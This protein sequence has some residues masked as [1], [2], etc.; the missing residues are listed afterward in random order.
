MGYPLVFFN[1]QRYI[2]GF[3][4]YL[5][6]ILNAVTAKIGGINYIIENE[7]NI[8]QEPAI[9]AIRHES[10]WETLILIHKFKEPIF[11]LKEELLNI[12]L[13]G[14][15]SRKAGTISI[16]RN[17]GVESLKNAISQVTKAVE[18]GH[19]VIIFPEGTRMAY[20]EYAPLKRG[21]ALFYKKTNCRVVPVIHNAG[22]LWPRR[23]FIK[24]QGTI[25]VKFLNPIV[26][27]LSDNEFMD[28]LNNVFSSEIKK[29][30]APQKALA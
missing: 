20:G 25:M 11:V 5:S 2:F 23:K 13:F 7:E 17:K 28:R 15:L 27:G 10:V 9:Y 22:S 18:Q 29:L 3:W 24:K 4:R 19:P 21:I 1:K 8:L 6:A 30:E 12:P 14:A 16:D 26:S